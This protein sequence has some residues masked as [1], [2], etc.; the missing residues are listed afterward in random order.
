M[1]ATGLPRMGESFF[2][3]ATIMIAIPSGVQIFCWI[4]TLWGGRPRFKTP[5]MYA[6][7]F[8]FIFVIGGM[9]GVMQGSLPL[10][11]QVHEPN[12]VIADFHYILLRRTDI[13]L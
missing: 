8:F 7:G 13:P 6:L 9:T 10:D 5:M 12:F 11:L 3:G 2:T 1:F 4:A